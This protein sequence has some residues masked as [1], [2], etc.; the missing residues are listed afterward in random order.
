MGVGRWDASSRAAYNT[1]TA[2]MSGKSTDHVFS[3]RSV[4]NAIRDDLNPLGVKMRESR[5]SV[6]NP[7]SNAIIVGLD[8][9]GSMGMIADNIA[10]EGLGKLFTK[11]LDEK[12]VTDPHLM[13]MGIGDANWDQAPL[14]VSQF[15]AD[16]RIIEQ[17]TGM[18]IEHGGGGNLFESYN[19]PWYFAALHT[20]IDCFEKRG[21]KGYLFTVGDEQAPGNLTKD[22]IK[23]FI[24]DDVQTDPDNAKL[25]RAVQERYHVFH[26]MIAEGS[27]ARGH[28]DAVRSSWT[29]FLGQNAIWLK[30]YRALA[31][32]IVAAIAAT[33]GATVSVA[34]AALAATAHL[35]S[36]TPRLG[37]SP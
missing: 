23:R 8:V 31:D 6:E 24:G 20:A 26:I 33:E 18:W 36:K 22:Q 19:L 1:S 3:N 7:M 34:P 9:T 35:A 2:G 25:L 4:H 12:P 28:E 21:R 17:L 15:E 11:I 14:Q 16:A 10:R 27:H 29:S 30:D 32:T 37:H 13:F 5:D